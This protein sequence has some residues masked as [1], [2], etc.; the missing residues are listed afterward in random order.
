MKNK[1]GPVRGC[2]RVVLKKN[3]RTRSRYGAWDISTYYKEQGKVLAVSLSSRP[4][5]DVARW[6]LGKEYSCTSHFE[7][8]EYGDIDTLQIMDVGPA[9][10]CKVHARDQQAEEVSKIRAFL[11]FSTKWG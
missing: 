9:F 1:A 6:V 5:R 2:Q 8:V 10:Y 3:H 4:K 11:H 7:H